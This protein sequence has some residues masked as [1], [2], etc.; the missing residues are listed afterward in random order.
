MSDKGA[1]ASLWSRVGG[2]VV[3]LASTLSAF[4]VM[5]FASAPLR[6]N[7]ALALAMV[8]SSLVSCGGAFWLLVVTRNPLW[9]LALLP[10]VG[11]IVVWLLVAQ[12]TAFH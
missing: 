6:M 9:A 3:I 4:L 7:G 5:V 12:M 2:V 8:A 11:I 10:V 1:P